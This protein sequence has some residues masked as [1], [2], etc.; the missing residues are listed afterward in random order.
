MASLVRP[1]DEYDHTSAES[2]AGEPWG[3]ARGTCQRGS[4]A[5]LVG[6][7]PRDVMEITDNMHPG[8]GWRSRAESGTADGVD[9]HPRCVAVGKSRQT[10]R[11]VVTTDG[12]R[13]RSEPAAKEADEK[14][15]WWCR[16]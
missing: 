12:R 15:A 1:A 13:W 10:R 9:R 8:Q 3:V 7:E 14:E 2:R 4:P 11:E 16:K 6:E 5:G